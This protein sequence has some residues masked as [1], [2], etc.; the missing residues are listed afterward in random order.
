ME[1]GVLRHRGVA[2][3]SLTCLL[4]LGLGERRFDGMAEYPCQ[5]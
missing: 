2:W 4:D 1:Y 3:V 5:H